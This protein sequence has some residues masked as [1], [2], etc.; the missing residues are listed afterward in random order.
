LDRA[1]E[2]ACSASILHQTGERRRLIVAGARIDAPD[3]D[4]DGG[5]FGIGL[6]ADNWDFRGFSSGVLSLF[7]RRL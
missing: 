3:L 4:G 1:R 5:V 2:D 6:R 7:A